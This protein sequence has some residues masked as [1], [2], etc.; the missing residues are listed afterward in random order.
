[1]RPERG[2][3]DAA[4]R[5]SQRDAGF[6]RGDGAAIVVAMVGGGAFCTYALERLTAE[7]AAAPPAA[8]LEVHIFNRTPRFG[9]GL[10][11]DWNQAATSS[12]NRVAS[13]IAFAADDSNLAA[14]ALLPAA[15][16]PTFVE[17]ARR[18]YEASGEARYDLQPTDIPTRHLHGEALVEAFARYS[19]LLEHVPG[20]RVALHVDEVVD[21]RPV[22]PD[23]LELLARRTRIE[24]DV[25]LLVTG[26]P[27]NRPDPAGEA[28]RL[29]AF[30]TAC[31][32][33]RFVSQA[34]PLDRQLTAETA[35]AGAAVALIGM[36]LTAID[37][38]LHLTEGR[39]GRFDADRTGRLRY[40]RSGRE[41]ATIVPT[42]PSGLFP[43]T[44][45][46][47]GKATDGSGRDHGRLEHKP[48]FL[49]HEAVRM[50]RRA[51][52]VPAQ[53]GRRR[54]RQLDFRRHVFPLLV[55]ELAYVHYRT[56][57][58][59]RDDVALAASARPA[60]ATF[61]R[62]AG[63]PS[64]PTLEAL[65]DPLDRAARVRGLRPFR[66]RA[67]FEPA[68]PA[69]TAD[70][71][72]WRRWF[73]DH[74]DADVAAARQGNLTHPEKAA[75]DGVWRDLRSVL[76]AVV[77]FGGLTA[78]SQ[79]EFV[80]IYW[81]HYN[82]M[83]NGA[84]IEAMRKILALCEDGLV[85]VGVGPEPVIEGDPGAGAFLIRGGL[86]G[87]TRRVSILLDARVHDFNAELDRCPLYR[88]LLAHGLVRRWRNPGPSR[89]EDFVPGSLDVSANFEAIGADGAADPRITV[90]GAPVEGTAFF[91]LSAARPQ[92]NSPILNAC[93]AWAKRVA[94]LARARPATIRSERR[95][96]S[97]P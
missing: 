10:A 33:L 17:W 18:R 38:I 29:A 85:D 2:L 63:R 12:M 32:G 19:G 81:R 80:R 92:S 39:G 1:M 74:L 94:A 36:G 25:A 52:G 65:L 8:G 45:P 13:Q 37:V 42:A 44:R 14:G 35:P 82:R 64:A 26:H 55:L 87:A 16:R 5:T 54:I 20:V 71:E 21:L 9:A 6:G 60:W 59:V 43:G 88:N 31:S 77:D 86:T 96:A 7:V 68:P 53:L 48:A 95:A 72:R 56:Q 69:E 23:R 93:G 11:Q 40:R 97:A 30:A 90:L 41:P 3:T 46:F 84:G 58:R 91:Q 34:Y 83:S 66:W 61:L 79:R 70:Q 27:D 67:L 50:L 76:S 4:G 28:G 22:G 75:C 89:A 49:T 15:A 24:A 73:L 62:S 57:L 51:V 47:N 78:A